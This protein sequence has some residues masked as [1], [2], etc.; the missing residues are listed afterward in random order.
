ME[1]LRIRKTHRQVRASGKPYA[2]PLYVKK[3]R[4]YGEIQ[5]EKT[6]SV[7]RPIF[8][9]GAA[10]SGK[11]RWVTRLYA[12]SDSIWT[13]PK[14]PAL[15]LNSLSPIAQW[16]DSAQIKDWY[17]ADHPEKPFHKLKQYERV[18]L[19][20]EYLAQTQSILFIDDAHRLSGRKLQIARLALMASKIFVVSASEE[21]RI[22][23]NLRAVILRREP[24]TYRLKSDVAYDATPLLMWAA[25]AGAVMAGWWEAAFVLGGL[26]AMSTG[27]RA[28]RNE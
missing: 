24:Q 10:D 14:F 3:N 26:K 9:T 5:S 16:T 13:K 12:D 17:N 15:L 8:V 4:K 11:S 21:Q 20:P 7:K 6:I 27:R 19:I 25:I 1:Y 22:A 23:P 18:D 2:V 28:S